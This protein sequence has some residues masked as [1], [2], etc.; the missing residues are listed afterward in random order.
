ME[1]GPLS[2]SWWTTVA[3]KDFVPYVNSNANIDGKPDQKLFSKYDL[4]GWPSVLLLDYDGTVLYGP[5]VD[6]N[7]KKAFRPTHSEVMTV[8]LNKIAPLFMVRAKV[9]KL[10]PGEAGWDVLRAELVLREALVKPGRYDYDAV[11]TA[12]KVPGLD[13]EL[14]RQALDLGARVPFQR[15]YE[16]YEK[17]YYGSPNL[18]EQRRARKKAMEAT[19]ALYKRGLVIEDR[20]DDLHHRFWL[21]AI[22]GALAAKDIKL[23]GEGIATYERIYGKSPAGKREAEKRKKSLRKLEATPE[24]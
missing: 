13:P 10:K 24:K 21:L 15:V 6:D 12:S 7:N 17:E 18:R 16:T 11:V 23:A 20:H 2:Q 8:A 14:V 3:S 9:A 22:D 1:R 5:F 19:Y 4:K